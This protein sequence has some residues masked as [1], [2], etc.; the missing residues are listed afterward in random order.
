MLL[1]T[2]SA[3]DTRNNEA[4]LMFQHI[5]S[6]LDDAIGE[7]NTLPQHLN[8]SFREF[9]ADLNAVARRHFECH[10]RGSPRPPKPYT[11]VQNTNQMIE[12]Q[13]M[14]TKVPQK[15]SYA[16]IASTAP[17]TNVANAAAL[18]QRSRPLAALRPISNLKQNANTIGK[19]QPPKQV[20][21]NRLLVR[22]AAGHPALSM[23]PF[24]VMQQ[25][26]TFL[27]EKWV[28]EVQHTKT[29]FAICP[30]HTAAQ[31]NLS[32]RI[33]DIQTFLSTSGECKVEKPC[34][35]AAYRLSGVPRSYAGYNVS[36]NSIEMVEITASILTEALTDLT[37]V[38]P[39]NVLESRS[40][41]S[42]DFYPQKSWIVLYPK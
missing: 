33:D 31:E 37:N 16:T 28:R 39:I 6:V 40:T 19:A 18:K 15:K 41:S 26:N 17:P 29:G 42:S 30:A 10:V 2:T 21:D 9:V 12:H 35:H 34:E 24:A 22:V 23:S 4:T 3:A 5:A 36:T 32:N 27:G 7:N 8:R 38:A 14:N 13:V 1:S 20:E 11:T 25:I